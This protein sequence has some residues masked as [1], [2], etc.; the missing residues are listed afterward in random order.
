MIY[1]DLKNNFLQLQGKV[2][3][4]VDDNEMNQLVLS[5]IFQNAGL[6]TIQAH[7]GTEAISKLLAGLKPDVILMDLEMPVMNGL[8][9][10]EFI[11]NEIDPTMPIIINSGFI[12]MH[13]KLKLNCLGIFDFLEKPYNIKDIFTKILKVSIG[14]C[15]QT[16]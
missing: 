3:L 6:K 2:V 14:L 5:K 8:Q 15:K 1:N 16:M 10:S 12:S 4:N 7:N 13:Q 11:R 9:T